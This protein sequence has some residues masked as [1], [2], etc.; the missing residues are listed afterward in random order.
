MRGK[1]SE[2][3]S[4]GGRGEL[5]LL[6]RIRRRATRS[7]SVG[8]RLG[9]G[10]DCAIL[11]LKP[12]EELVVTTDL[13]IAGRHFQLE[14]HPPEVVGHRTLTRGLSDIAAMGAR[15]IAAFLSLGLPKNL[16]MAKGRRSAWVDGVLAGFLALAGK[17]EMPLAGGGLAE[18]PIVMADLA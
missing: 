3:I 10:D 14:W 8:L 2:L 5:V 17:Y 15:P 9:I 4:E 16:T 1:R 6:D 18:S 12:R 13:S 7:E 11:R